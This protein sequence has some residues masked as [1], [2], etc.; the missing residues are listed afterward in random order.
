MAVGPAA[1]FLALLPAESVVPVGASSD[2]NAACR[3]IDLASI[4]RSVSPPAEYGDVDPEAAIYFG[5]TQPSVHL[6]FVGSNTLLRQIAFDAQVSQFRASSWR[7]HIDES[8]QSAHRFDLLLVEASSHPESG[9]WCDAFA[10][11]GSRRAQFREMLTTCRASGVPVACWFREGIASFDDWAWLAEGADALFA[12]DPAV[13]ARLQAQYPARA[14]QWM[15]PAIQ[16]RQHHPVRVPTLLKAARWA[17]SRTLFD[18]LAEC[19]GEGRLPP[20][21]DAVDD[22][23]LGD[24]RWDVPLAQLNNHPQIAR[25]ALGTYGAGDRSAIL[26]L[27]G[28]EFFDRGDTAATQQAQLEAAACGALVVGPAAMPW[29]AADCRS[30]DAWPAVLADPVRRAR[31]SHRAMRL[32]LS[33]HTLA[34]R[35]QTMLDAVG[36]RIRL[37]PLA[38]Q[39]ACLL[40]TRRPD[41]LDTCLQRFRAD[42]YPNKELVVVV[43]DDDV[44]LGGIRQSI[45]THEPIRILRLGEQYSLGACLNYA[46]EHTD[47]TYWAKWD[48]DDFYG[49]HYLSDFML[50]RRAMDFDVAGK[51]MAFTWL[52]ESG[53]LLWDGRWGA[54]ANVLRSAIDKRNT[55][56]AGATLVGHRR[57]LESVPF[58]DARR[59]GTDSEFLRRCHGQGWSLLSTDPFNFVRYRTTRE[60]FHTWQ[61]GEKTLR[62]RSVRVGGQ[63]DIQALAFL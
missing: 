35:L 41:L 15:P 7:R 18:H 32:V 21:L 29:L 33:Q 20:G 14:V 19:V 13:V 60:G 3:R 27:V 31:A 6:A 12:H 54:R 44:D 10:T 46:F 53:E 22:L 51:P 52:H 37:A 4:M 11:D 26:R 24:S 61:V 40:V 47:A 39:V 9:D 62:D 16:P 38:P 50:Y 58:P 8:L 34:D 48:D 43:H 55:G 25:R 1:E 56:V 49:P 2:P 42:L 28:A 5:E 63:P 36:G 57:V 45:G 30:P 17:G 59:R 23:L